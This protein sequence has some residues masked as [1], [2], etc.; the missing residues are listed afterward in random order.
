[1]ITYIKYYND[2]I[3]SKNQFIELIVVQN[4]QKYM[5]YF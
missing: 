2:T 4:Y 5:D 1:M 3:K